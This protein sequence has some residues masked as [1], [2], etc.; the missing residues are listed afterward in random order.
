MRVQLAQVHWGRVLSA[1]IL[2]VL[3]TIIGNYIVFLFVLRIWGQL[4]QAVPVFF[5]D[6]I[7]SSSLLILLLTFVFAL[8][9]VSNVKEEPRL[10]GFLVGF[11]AA[12]FFFFISSGFQGKFALVTAV[13][14]TLMIVA[15]WFGGFLGGRGR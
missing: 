7:C 11:I 13:T 14:T 2:V 1:S 6:G 5:L 15:G 8:W 3:L 4:K 10:H 9:V 12:L